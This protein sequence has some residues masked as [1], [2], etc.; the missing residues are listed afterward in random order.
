[1]KKIKNIKKIITFALATVCMLCSVACGGKEEPENEVQEIKK[2]VNNFK[3]DLLNFEQ[4]YPDFSMTRLG[5][6]A[7]KATRNA[8]KAFVKTGDYS[9]FIRTMGGQAAYKNP[10]F[11]FPTSS[12]YYGF[13][14]KDFTKVDYVSAW[15]YNDNE[16]DKR[17]VMGL[18]TDYGMTDPTMLK[19]D[20][21]VLKAKAW[22]NVKYYVDFSALS[23]GNKIDEFTA[24]NILGV[25]L[26]FEHT[27][28]TTLDNA[29]KY[30]LDDMSL[31][32]RDTPSTIQEVVEFKQ[33]DEKSWEILNFEESWQ[34]YVFDTIETDSA[35][36]LPRHSVV[37][38]SD[39]DV[40]ATS[41]KNVLKVEFPV[42]PTS[43]KTQYLSLPE[44]FMRK[45]YSTFFYD[46]SRGEGSEHVI[47]EEEWTNYG[48]SFD[49]YCAEDVDQTLIVSFW[50]K[51]RA[52]PAGPFEDIYGKGNE[53]A[54]SKQWTTYTCNLGAMA[55]KS[56]TDAS[57]ANANYKDGDRLKNSGCMT[58]AWAGSKTYTEA[59]EDKFNTVFFDNFRLV[60]LS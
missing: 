31:T 23:A 17:L 16:T 19:G 60:K 39:Y 42:K 59:D 48:L 30:Y 52:T 36:T 47:P 51:N 10:V 54:R 22:T 46:A 5:T 27:K 20:E 38:A 21:F 40:M 15:L 7:G 24:K 55:L 25:Y 8:D 58:I 3:A 2:I 6:M 12:A 4:W 37:K 41:G 53:I 14:Y 34:K 1:M 18:V 49:V 28:T 33:I 43:A 50:M 44:D 57:M 45:L 9:M 56:A 26:Q 35:K 13:D 32:F 29:P 11:W